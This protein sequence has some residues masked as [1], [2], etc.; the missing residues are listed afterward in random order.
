M[1]RAA[2]ELIY[3]SADGHHHWHLQKIARYSLWN[4]SKTAEVAPA[5]K[6]GFCLDDSQHVETSIGPVECRL[7][8][9]RRPLPRIL[10]AL[11]AQRDK[12]VRGHLRRLARC[13]RLLARASSGST[14]R[15]SCP[16]EYWLREDVNPLGFV[17]ETSEANAPVYSTTADGR[18]RVSTRSPRP[19]KRPPGSRRRSRSPP[20]R[21]KTR[22]SRPTRSSPAPRTGR[23]ARSTAKASSPTRRPPGSPG[24]DTFT[25]S[26]SDASSNFPES[27]QVAT[28]SVEVTSSTQ[29]AVSIEGAPASMQAGS[30]VQLSAKVVND[31]PTVTWGASA[32]A[33]TSEGTYTAPAE[34]PAGGTVRVTA[35][36]SKGA[37]AEKKIE[38]TPP[39][40][41]AERFSRATP[42]R[43]TRS[44]TRRPPGER[45]RSS[46]P[47]K[48]PA[49]SKNSCSARTPR[50][51]RA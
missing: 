27:P 45:K 13:L 28:V 34:V 24:T 21:S 36:T 1:K 41:D 12:P 3:S 18:V 30:S 42:R 26:A 46:S 49:K 9:Q 32:G 14:S 17:K 48:R 47:R 50:R 38:I 7:R 4:A 29:P 16:G 6:V 11:P 51:T 37:K 31:S 8:R 15:T 39:C 40:R 5:Q 33:I 10:R 25:F 2:G 43:P 23:W 22:T 35:T 19:P 20:K 44:A